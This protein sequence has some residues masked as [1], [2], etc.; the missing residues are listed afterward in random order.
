[1][2]YPTSKYVL[3]PP[4]H[5]SYN[6]KV[7]TIHVDGKVVSKVVGVNVALKKAKITKY[8]NFTSRIEF[9]NANNQLVWSR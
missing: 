9:R 1:M 4:A 6:N 5:P 3:F 2:I 8:D 7:Y